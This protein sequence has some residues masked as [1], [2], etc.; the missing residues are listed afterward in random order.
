[1][2]V[3]KITNIINDDIYIGKT[4]HPIIDR[5]KR[6]CYLASLG[7]ETYLHRAIR[8]YGQDN[9]YQELIEEVDDECLL[10]EREI[11]WI[12]NLSPNY[13]MTKGGDGGDT[14]SS[15]KYQEYMK[16]R[17]ELISGEGNPFYGKSH[18]EETKRKI[19]EAKMGKKLSEEHKRKISEGGKGKKLTKKQI[20][21]L[22]ESH[23]KVYH[24]ITPNGESITIKNLSKFC[25]ENG[26]DQRNMNTMYRGGYKSSKGYTRN[27]DISDEI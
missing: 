26:L 21:A 25:R 20:E 22:V 10:N 5:F 4:I 27:I 3:Y 9:F 8:K 2:Y 12:E 1:M 6:H 13:N 24:L 14:S 17:S 23:S 19:S 15:D 7:S 11:Y 16:L 18:S